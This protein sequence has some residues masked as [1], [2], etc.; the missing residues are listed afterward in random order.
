MRTVEQ[1]RKYYV[2]HVVESPAG[3]AR[4]EVCNR[5]SH[6]A[7]AMVWAHVRIKVADS[8]GSSRNGR[9]WCLARNQ[10]REL[11]G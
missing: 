9:G 11:V 3:E 4:T 10:L 6:Q 5:I 8:V 2:S 1:L 7:Q